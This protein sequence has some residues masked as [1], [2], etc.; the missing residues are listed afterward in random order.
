MYHCD[1]MIECFCLTHFHVYLKFNPKMDCTLE[2][3]V[4]HRYMDAEIMFGQKALQLWKQGYKDEILRALAHELCHIVTSEMADAMKT[5]G[6]PET[7]RAT[8]FEER[9][10]ET[11]SRVYYR[12]YTRWL[13]ERKK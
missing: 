13:K 5:K 3:S 12:L 1:L 7:I 10:T 4:D 9:V 6:K 8:H 11:V 2:I